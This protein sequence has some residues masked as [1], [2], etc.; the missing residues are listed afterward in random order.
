MPKGV[1]VR[2]PLRVPQIKL[3]SVLHLFKVMGFDVPVPLKQVKARYKELAKLYHPD[4]CKDRGA[5]DKFK[6]I[7][8]AYQQ[9]IKLDWQP[10][11][12]E[13][14]PQ[15]PP[16]TPKPWAEQVIWRWLDPTKKDKSY[17]ITYPNAFILK[18]TRFNFMLGSEFSVF[19]DEEKPLPTT[20]EVSF[21]K[22]TVKIKIEE[23]YD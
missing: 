16:S 9:L 15:R 20:I 4:V 7:N 22:E 10:P 23:G 19:Y 21:G 6:L 13:S 14:A 18:N 8:N 2:V 11:V 17:R 12:S 3:D 1:G 5:E